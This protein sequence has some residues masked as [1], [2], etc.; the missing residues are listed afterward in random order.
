VRKPHEQKTELLFTLECSESSSLRALSNL[1]AF[2]TLSRVRT[3]SQENI[4]RPEVH[5]TSLSI[6]QGQQYQHKYF[7]TRITLK[8]LSIICERR[9]LS[10]QMIYRWIWFRMVHRGAKACFVHTKR[11]IYPSDSRSSHKVKNDIY[12]QLM[13]FRN[14][15]H[16]HRG[17]VRQ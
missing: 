2:D 8:D 5:Q 9:N 13:A 12:F 16:H 17:R 11:S 7:C 1:T 6:E 15:L 3:R 14:I 4:T 10:K